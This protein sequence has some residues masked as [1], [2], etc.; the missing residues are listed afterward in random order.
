MSVCAGRTFVFTHLCLCVDRYNSSK[1]FL[2]YKMT[3]MV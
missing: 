1:V 3:D 2:F